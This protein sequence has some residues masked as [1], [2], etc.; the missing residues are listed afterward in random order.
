MRDPRRADASTLAAPE[1][2]EP[3]AVEPPTRAPVTVARS[4]DAVPI[5]GA[6]QAA[7]AGRAALVRWE[8]VA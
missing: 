6:F 2:V 8:G 7:G 1:T 4:Y 3:F 5:G